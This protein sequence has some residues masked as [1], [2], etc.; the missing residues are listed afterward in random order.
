[1]RG[2]LHAW[3]F[4]VFAALGIGL[5]VAKRDSDLWPSA[6]FA[7]SVVGVFGTSALYHRVRWSRVWY[8][9]IRR[10]DHTMIFGLIMGTYTPIFVVALAGR[11]ETVFIAAWVVTAAG[12]LMTLLWPNAPKWARSLV[13]VGVGW[14]GVP[15]LPDLV[16]AIG[17]SGLSMLVGGGVAYSVGAVIYALKR[18]NP[19]P[20][21]FGYHEIFH[22]L[23]I[24]AVAVHYAVITFW[25]L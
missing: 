23:V 17:W 24:A 20:D 13:Y 3:A 10:L 12:V 21:V 25:V 19:F 14:I 18:P 16:D 4:F 15:V 8:A 2:V 22:A 9:R 1:M 6:I 11:A 5:V 7:L